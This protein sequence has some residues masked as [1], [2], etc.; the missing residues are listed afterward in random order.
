MSIEL[1]RDGCWVLGRLIGARSAMFPVARGRS[2]VLPVNRR[3]REGAGKVRV[4]V[5][6]RAAS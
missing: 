1:P 2:A 3:R 5:F 4:S 6:F